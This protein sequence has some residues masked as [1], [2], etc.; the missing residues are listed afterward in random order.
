M[1]CWRGYTDVART[2]LIEFSLDAPSSARR[3]AIASALKPTRTHCVRTDRFVVIVMFIQ[4]TLRSCIFISGR[5][6]KLKNLTPPNVQSKW[7]QMFLR[8]DETG[9]LA[10]FV[11]P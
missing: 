9:R 8:P 2:R 11:L 6:K 10:L 1:L 3:N 4:P 7:G 5:A